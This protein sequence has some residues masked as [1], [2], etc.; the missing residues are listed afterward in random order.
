MVYQGSKNRYAK[1]IIPIINKI[2]K[3]NN[4][5]TFVDLCSGGCNIVANPKYDIDVKNKMAI[6]NNKYLISLLEKVKRNELEFRFIEKDEYLKVKYN[7][8]HFEDWFVAYCAFLCSFGSMWFEAYIGFLKDKGKIRN[9]QLERYNNLLNQSNKLKEVKLEYNDI[10]DIDF[11]KFDKN[12]LFYIDPPYSDVIGYHNK[13]DNVKF[14]DLV[15]TLSKDFIVLISE[16]KA[17]ENFISIWETGF[18]SRLNNC[19]DASKIKSYTE[20]L[21]IHKDNLRKIGYEI[22][23]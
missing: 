23:D 6:D 18:K 15:E 10:F 21:F 5:T 22:K 13:F 19:V 2:I 1:F 9:M 17:P 14:W 11:S 7:K 3:N 4:I 20:N 8:E 12:T 16:Y